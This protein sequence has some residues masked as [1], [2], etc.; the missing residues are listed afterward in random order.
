VRL[1]PHG[2]H[3]EGGDD[4]RAGGEAISAVELTS[5][6]CPSA[7]TIASTFGKSA[8][9]T[10]LSGLVTKGLVRITSP[11][12]DVRRKI[13]HEKYSSVTGFCCANAVDDV[14]TTT[15]PSMAPTRRIEMLFFI[16]TSSNSHQVT[17]VEN[18]PLKWTS[19]LFPAY[20]DDILVIVT[21]DRS[22]ERSDAGDSLRSP[23][24]GQVQSHLT[25]PRRR[26]EF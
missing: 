22:S 15:P 25:G 21:A 12:G 18:H 13:D 23:P 4:L 16:G 24:S 3:L 5:S 7:T 17:F 9:F 8:T 20:S 26:A 6:G 1:E 2:V 10:G 14:K 11:L 19:L